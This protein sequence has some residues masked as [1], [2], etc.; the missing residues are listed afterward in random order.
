MV[1][2]SFLIKYGIVVIQYTYIIRN[3]E[4]N[5]NMNSKLEIYSFW[6][7]ILMEIEIQNLLILTNFFK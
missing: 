5:L 6:Q 1:C 3:H 7:L 2:I 4:I